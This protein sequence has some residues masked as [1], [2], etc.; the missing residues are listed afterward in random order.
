MVRTKKRKDVVLPRRFEVHAVPLRRGGLASFAEGCEFILNDAS[1]RGVRVVQFQF[2]EGHG[3]VIVI[4]TQQETMMSIIPLAVREALQAAGKQEEGAVVLDERMQSALGSF[5]VK[6]RA[7]R[8][9]EGSP[10]E[11]KELREHLRSCFRSAGGAVVQEL[12][13]NLQRFMTSHEG[14][15]SEKDGCSTLRFVRLAHQALSENL[16]EALH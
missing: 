14:N 7:A 10:T 16:K 6:A 12:L 11:L 13:D 2:I 4:D 1:H 15:C 5:L 9:V 8:L 3:A